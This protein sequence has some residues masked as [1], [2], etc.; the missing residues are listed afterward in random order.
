LRTFIRQLAKEAG[1]VLDWKRFNTDAH[2]RDLLY[3]ARDRGVGDLAVME[4]R[5]DQNLRA[6]VFCMD[7]YEKNPGLADLLQSAI[8]PTR[9]IAFEKLP[10]NL[11]L[12]K[13][14][15]LAETFKTLHRAERY[16]G[17]KFSG[18]TARQQA[19]SAVKACVQA[20]LDEGNTR[21]FKLDSGKS[22]EER[23]SKEYKETSGPERG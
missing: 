17:E 22:P 4:I 8:R 7:K 12:Q 18:E 23:R 9:A 2:M 21:G 14:P 16:F 19:M 1:Y 5:N 13:H 20:R 10:E 15:E 3:I 11:A 6:V